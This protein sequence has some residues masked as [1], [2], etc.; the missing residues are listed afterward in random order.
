LDRGPRRAAKEWQFWFERS[1]TLP[2]GSVDCASVVALDCSGPQCPLPFPR[3][4]Q[5]VRESCI[6]LSSAS[7]QQAGRQAGRQ[8][9]V[10]SDSSRGQCGGAV[11]C[12]VAGPVG[13][14]HGCKLHQGFGNGSSRG[15][16]QARLLRPSPCLVV[17]AVNLATEETCSG[18]RQGT[19]HVTLRRW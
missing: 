11:Q 1:M 13:A 8:E 12:R 2:E 6:L 18:F 7:T 10:S 17:I 16:F 9:R 3:T 14:A 15:T 19:L 4:A 5:V